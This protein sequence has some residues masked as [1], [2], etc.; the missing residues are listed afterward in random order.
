[1]YF[2][3]LYVA[4]QSGAAIPAILYDLRIVPP[5]GGYIIFLIKTLIGRNEEDTLSLQ[6]LGIL[7]FPLY[8]SFSMRGGGRLFIICARTVPG[9]NLYR[10]ERRSPVSNASNSNTEA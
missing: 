9:T 10:M 3:E 5:K 6:L 7:R 1:M 2:I 4:A 8:F